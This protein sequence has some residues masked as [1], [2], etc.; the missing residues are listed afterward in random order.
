MM[1]NTYLRNSNDGDDIFEKLADD[2][3]DVLEK[4]SDNDIF[5]KFLKFTM[6]LIIYLKRFL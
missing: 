1:P 2:A 4:V 3:K 5:E 6:M